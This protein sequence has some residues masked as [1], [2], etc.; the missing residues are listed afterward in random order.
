LTGQWVE[1]DIRDQIVGYVKDLAAKAELSR[2]WLIQLIGISPSRFYEW[3][4]RLGQPNFHNCHIPKKHWLLPQERSAVVDY[5]QSRIEEGYRRLTYMMLD[6]NIVAASPATIYRIL[7]EEGLLF[8]WQP[9]TTAKKKGFDQPHKIH[10]HWHVDISYIKIL[11]VFFFLISVLEGFSRF[12]LH[13][14]LR[15]NMTETDVEITIERAREKFPNLNP[16]LINDNGPQFISKE[17]KEYIRTCQLEQVF[18]SPFHPQSNGKLERF[19]RTIKT[20]EIRK[21][22]YL[23]L[24]DARIKIEQY[25]LYYN[26]IRLHSAIYYLTPE[27]VLMGRMEQRLKQRQDKLDKAKSYREQQFKFKAEIS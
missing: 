13:H 27:D 19:H 10:Q 22:S 1:P 14:E 23:S 17:F 21:N 18:T 2:R 9:T 3:Q 15:I 16:R 7:K 26:T 8:R 12:I 5:C 6:E 24:Q 25:I 11:G 20:E 4:Q